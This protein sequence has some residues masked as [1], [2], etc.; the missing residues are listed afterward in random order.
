MVHQ[1][2]TVQIGCRQNTARPAEETPRG[3][4]GPPFFLF[5]NEYGPSVQVRRTWLTVAAYLKVSLQSDK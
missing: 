3:R 5:E 2:R 4:V 1:K